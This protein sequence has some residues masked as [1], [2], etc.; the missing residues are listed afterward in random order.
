[1]FS[2]NANTLVLDANR[3]ADLL[4][5]GVQLDSAEATQ[6]LNQ[7]ESSY[8]YLIFLADAELTPWSQKAIRH[9]DLVLAVA[10]DGRRPDTQR[11]RAARRRLRQHRGA[12]PRHR[13]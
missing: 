2:A 11:A 3:A 5:K 10:T 8:D 13:A 4:P 12:P 7:L 6:A 9:A 1:M